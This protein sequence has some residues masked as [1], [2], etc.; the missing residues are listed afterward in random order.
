MLLK[1]E[2][3]FLP[4]FYKLKLCIT[5]YVQYI[6]IYQIMIKINLKSQTAL[7]WVVFNIYKEIILFT[8]LLNLSYKKKRVI[9]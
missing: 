2:N 6:L 1:I 9:M 8:K 4:N 7:N 3:N 5:I